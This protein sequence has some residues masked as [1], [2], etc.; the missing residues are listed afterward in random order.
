MSQ[1]FSAVLPTLPLDRWLAAAHSATTADVRAIL[2][3]GGARSVAEFAQ[4]LSPAARPLLED[5]AALAQQTT[6]RNFGRTIRLF[7]PIYLSNECVNICTYCGFSRHNDIPRI[8]IPVPQVVAETQKLAQQGFRSLLIVAGEHPKYVSNGYVVDV[9]RSCLPLMPSLAIELGPMESEGYRPLVEAGCEGLIVYQETYHPATYRA[10]HTAGPKKD[11]DFRLDTA[12]RG[13][14]AGFRRLGIGALYGLHDWRYE[15]LCAAAHAHHLHRQC[16]KAQLSI[17]FPRMRPAAGGFSP[18]PQHMMSDAELVQLIAATR[19]FLPFIAIVV[20]TREHPTLRNGLVAIGTTHMSAGSSTEPGGY[21]HFDDASWSA[22]R[23]QPGEQF[24]IA[25]ERP[26]RVVAAM[27]RQQ[28][29]EPV[30]KDFDQA[31][32]QAA[33]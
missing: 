32:V 2:Q 9:I 14:E 1:Y 33:G 11:F 4:L 25:D 17:S 22:N 15:A 10:L 18:Q 16:W 19:L 20:S 26:P 6:R 29:Y 30:W 8:T 12:E 3:R 27:I 24:H 31:L 21:S 13:Y 7:A 23:D 28:G 5:M